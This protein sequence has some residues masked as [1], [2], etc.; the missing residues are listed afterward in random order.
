VEKRRRYAACA[1]VT[2]KA[3]NLENLVP[4]LVRSA[5][6]SLLSLLCSLTLLF[7]LLSLSDT[8]VCGLFPR[9]LQIRS[10]GRKAIRLA[11][12]RLFARPI[13]IFEI[14][15]NRESGE[16]ERERVR[17]REGEGAGFA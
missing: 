13:Y 12:R 8:P 17:E 14:F 10:V 15:L 5:L 3:R 1:N 9:A 6:L 11:V 16:R 7:L 2:E 4:N